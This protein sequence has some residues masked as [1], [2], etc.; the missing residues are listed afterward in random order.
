MNYIVIIVT[1]SSVIL[2]IIFKI[3]N[4]S[5]FFPTLILILAIILDII[6]NVVKSKKDDKELGKSLNKIKEEVKK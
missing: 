1:L 4:L 2:A 6:S 5:M 3:K